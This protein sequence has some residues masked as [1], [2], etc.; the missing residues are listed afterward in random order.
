MLISPDHIRPLLSKQI[1][2]GLNLA[3][4]SKYNYNYT[5]ERTNSIINQAITDVLSQIQIEKQVESNAQKIKIII[6]WQCQ[7][8][9]NTHRASV[10]H[11]HYMDNGVSKI[12][13]SN[14]YEPV[15][16]D[17]KQYRALVVFISRLENKIKEAINEING[18]ENKER[19][20]FRLVTGG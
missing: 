11:N 17:K 19:S 9:L 16:F 12:D 15:Q 18:I 10:L 3:Y 14:N 13:Q 4:G 6:A 7:L 1:V 8:I 20:S 2:H 5:T